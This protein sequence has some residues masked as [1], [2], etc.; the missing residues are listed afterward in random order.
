MFEDPSAALPKALLITSG[1]LQPHS[2][3]KSLVPSLNT[4]VLFEVSP[5]S[6]HQVGAAAL[7]TAEELFSTSVTCVCLRL[8]RLQRF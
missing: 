3:V 7:L 6:F 5:V 8:L 1:H 4:L 2:I